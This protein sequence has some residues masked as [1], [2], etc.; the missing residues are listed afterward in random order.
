MK[1][2]I[3]ASFPHLSHIVTDR[4]GGNLRYEIGDDSEHVAENRRRACAMIGA[5]P[6]RVV[7]AVQTHSKHIYVYKNGG[8]F[9]DHELRDFDAF[10]T[11]VPGIA[12]LVQIADCQ[13]VLLY[14]AVR[15]VVAVVHSGWKGSVQD[16]IG[17]TLRTMKR[18]FGTEG[19][20]V[21]AGISPSLGSCCSEFTDPVA[22]L[23]AS[24]HQYIVPGN[25]VDFWRASQDQLMAEGIPADHIEVSGVCTV[26]HTDEYFSYRKE[27][28]E[29]G[30]FGVMA[31]LR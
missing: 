7:S 13:G 9:P 5:D 29:T 15:H 6:M 22:E 11:N 30:R 14:D 19:Q 1:L 16:V 3:F 10:V 26:D 20:D 27:N 28:G 25:R 17:E 8:Q 24:F 4:H 21:Y 18:E 31:I 23:P 12:L 2:S